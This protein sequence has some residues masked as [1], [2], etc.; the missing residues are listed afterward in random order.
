[1]ELAVVAIIVATSA[2]VLLH[3]AC[4]APT[5]AAR[6][7]GPCCA[8]CGGCPSGTPGRPAERSD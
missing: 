7:H 6:R 5:R 4:R 8:G 2:G 1:M 3:R